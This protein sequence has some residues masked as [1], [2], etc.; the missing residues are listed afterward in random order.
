MSEII[1]LRLCARSIDL[2]DQT[3]LPGD[4]R[5]IELF[6]I[7]S[8]CESI[9]A[10]RVRG[11]P[12]LGIAGAAGVWL[13][14]ETGRASDDALEAAASTLIGTRPT[15]VDLAARVREALS[16][17]KASG[18]SAETRRPALRAFTEDL[19]TERREQDEAMGRF[20]AELLRDGSAVLTHCNTGALATGG[21][22]TALGMIR[23][24]WE[25]GVLRECFATETRPLLQ[26]ARLTMWE[27]SRL[28]VPATL[29]P[30]TAAASLIAS[31]RVQ[32][33]VTGADRIAAN[34]DSANKIGT[35]GL[36]LAAARHGIP[37]YIVAPMSTV[38]LA[39]PDGGDISIEFRDASEV[40]GFGSQRWTPDEMPAYNPAFDVTPADLI[41]AIVTEWGVARPPFG[42][43]LREMAAR[44]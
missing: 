43:S 38:D 4:E 29:L 18:S 39:C 44:R 31:G 27:L 14:A 17:A 35:Y 10:L 7:E 32:A 41:A 3:L 30:D 20:G 11:A 24:A 12:L 13:A 5:Y 42:R 6:E 26:G 33:V 22:G 28:G 34:G 37:F 36:A 23:T 2:L 9:R 8:L 1:P 19:I 16:V 25:Q 15:A 21:I 40:G